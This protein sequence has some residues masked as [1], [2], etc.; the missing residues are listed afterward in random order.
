MKPGFYCIF[1]CLLWALFHPG[2][3]LSQETN[4]PPVDNLYKLCMNYNDW[5]VKKY[6]YKKG[7]SLP[8]L[9]DTLLISTYLCEIDTLAGK[10]DTSKS[11][12]LLTI[13]LQ[14]FKANATQ[15]LNRFTDVYTKPKSE[16]APFVYNEF[17]LLYSQM[18][19]SHNILLSAISY[20]GMMQ[21][22][23]VSVD[24]LDSMKVRMG[25][26][27][28]VLNDSID[29]TFVRTNSSIDSLNSTAK[30]IDKTVTKNQKK[31]KWA[32]GITGVTG[33]VAVAILIV[34]MIQ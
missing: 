6:N 20:S 19:L 15:Y 26:R 5:V 4:Y 12:R 3:T 1:I 7:R 22:L 2:K 25:K 28:K 9:M 13:P 34:T 10:L 27:I 33:I 30:S 11:N 8:T 17:N 21:K 29:S 31:L 16:I 23:Q 24:S 18:T 14:N 32:L